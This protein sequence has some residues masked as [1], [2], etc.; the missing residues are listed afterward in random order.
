MTTSINVSG[1]YQEFAVESLRWHW[2]EGVSSYNEASQ[3]E[4]IEGHQ[5]PVLILKK[6]SCC[7]EKNKVL[8]NLLMKSLKTNS[9]LEGSGVTCVM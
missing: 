8:W 3:R 4:N 1:V 6:C 5:S 9:D 2:S 7:L